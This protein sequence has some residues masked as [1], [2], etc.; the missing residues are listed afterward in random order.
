MINTP[1]T[2][3]AEQD[4][5]SAP[6]RPVTIDELERAGV[7]AARL[8]FVDNAGVAR[9]KCVPVERLAR[10]AERGVGMSVVMGTFTA[11]DVFASVPGYAAPVG[12]MRLVGDLS[13][14]Y[15]LP[16]APGWAWLPV[17][18]RDQAG[19]PWP[20]CQRS[21]LKRMVAQAADQGVRLLAALEVEWSIAKVVDGVR[22]PGHDGPSYGAAVGV[23]TFDLLLAVVDA[24][25]EAGVLVEQIHPEF[26]TGQ[27]E[28]SLPPV[29]PLEAA[30]QSVLARQVIR[31]VC[32]RHG[33]AA[34][35][36]PIAWRGGGGHGA[37][38]HFSV[39]RGGANL[40]TGGDRACGLAA[41]ADAFV[42]GVLEELPAMTLVGAPSPLSY[43]RLVPSTWSGA[44]ACW[45]HENREAALRLEAS[46]GPTASRSANV[47]WKS[48][49]TAANSYLVFGAI[50]AAGLDGM[51]REAELPPPVDMDPDTMAADE[52][53]A[54]G[55][56]RLPTSLVHAADRFDQSAVLREAMGEVLFESI[57]RTARAEAGYVEALD[58]D[59][60]VEHYW[61]RY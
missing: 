56:L 24:L 40:M 47:E 11:S 7:R 45:G 35:F 52:R 31:D 49:D 33:F 51:R 29:E 13:A 43:H 22:R 30:D 16:T 48:V 58:L 25:R 9:V 54:A 41:D 1:V 17:D 4:P 61:D 3:E 36:S 8:V 10:A 60:L 5:V 59:R 53:D 23:E 38:A 57:S 44:Y 6:D 27:L 20:G 26:G 42:A 37:H 32:E 46:V 15:T 55:Y 39:W 2:V 14:A 21:F 12:D 19:N 28:V 50:L 34:S 18:Q